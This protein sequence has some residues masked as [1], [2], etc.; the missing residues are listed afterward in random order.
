[1]LLISGGRTEQPTLLLVY[2][3]NNE[4]Q[5]LEAIYLWENQIRIW[6]FF[7]VGLCG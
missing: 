7:G 1:M 4:V 2:P 3:G 6:L 5:I